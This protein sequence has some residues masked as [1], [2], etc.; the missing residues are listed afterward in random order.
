M[1]MIQMPKTTKEINEQY[2]MKPFWNDLWYSQDE[3]DK[4]VDEQCVLSIIN[5]NRIRDEELNQ[6]QKECIA[7]CDMYVDNGDEA[8]ICNIIR[9]KLL[10]RF[11]LPFLHKHLGLTGKI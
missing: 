7:C 11:H 4:I 2:T 10:E 3:V 8:R 9:D 6:L 1:E 5:N